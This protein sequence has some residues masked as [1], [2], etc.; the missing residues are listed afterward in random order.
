MV[1]CQHIYLSRIHK[2]VC[3]FKR[4]ILENVIQ[5]Q[6]KLTKD[7]VVDTKI[8]WIVR[9]CI[10]RCYDL[11]P[12]ISQPIFIITISYTAK[13]LIDRLIG[14]V[15]H[16]YLWTVERKKKKQKPISKIVNH[17]NWTVITTI[18]RTSQHIS[19]LLNRFD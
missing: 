7:S 8:H 4:P 17:K 16:S 12:V 9:L 14:F 6:S 10:L 1:I 3:Y 11:G 19:E 15:L 13:N 18:K 5:S 2:T